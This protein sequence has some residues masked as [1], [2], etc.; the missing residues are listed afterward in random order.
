MSTKPI[1]SQ[2]MTITLLTSALLSP[3][4]SFAAPSGS[5]TW[6]GWTF[7]YDVSGKNDGLSLINVQY[8]GLPLIG[9]ISFP[10]MR[11]FYDNNACG[12]YA[13]R[14]GGTLSPVSWA[15]NATV[16]KRE[17]TLSGRQ[18][19][20][21][22]IRDVIG[23]Y[24]IYQ[25]YYLSND[26]ILDAHIYSKGLQCQVN[27][28]H[29]PN[30]R[31][32]FDIKDASNDQIQGDTISGYTTKLTE[33]NGNATQALNHGWRVKDS[34]TGNYI[35][36]Y[37]GFT[38]FTI[39]G[40]NETVPVTGYAN[41]TVFGRLYKS[42]EDVGWTYGPN[43]QVPYNNGE[44]IN[45]VDNVFWYEGYLPHS[46]AEGSS[47]WHSTG[48]RMVVNGALPPPPPPNETTQTFNN[49]AAI[50]I[51]DNTSASLYPSTINVAGMPG[52]V[53]NVIVKLNGVNHTYPD[54][55]DILLV[56]PNGQKVILMSDAG[57][58]VDLVNTNL[59]FDNTAS[60]SLPNSSGIATG[61]YRPTN[62]G[63]SDT[64]RTPAPTGSYGTSLAAFNGTAANG[65]WKLFI[66]DD[67]R[68]DL[69]SVTNGWS[70]IIT[71][72]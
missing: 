21:I 34:I 6:N 19:Y 13:D 18:W 45:N 32:D 7:N 55:V 30:W 35:D 15:G 66:M 62:F 64:F 16:A 48:L 61:I 41:N 2:M 10:V 3:T 4:I 26:G 5:V 39:P 25:V 36:I 8:Q 9:K 38:D 54:D 31:I 27:H 33:F 23:N 59:T 50:T 67:A 14:L 42:S 63:T 44:S 28:V 22:G 53:S 17:F 1:L 52:V 43:T 60:I 56:G 71:T 29:Y 72:Q 40:N 47:L 65:A 46:A 51:R 20:E 37:P 49:N 24:D 68:A 57:G 58:S 12:P 69:G 11:V 70:L